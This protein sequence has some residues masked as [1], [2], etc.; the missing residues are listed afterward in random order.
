MKKKINEHYDLNGTPE[1]QIPLKKGQEHLA[2]SGGTVIYRFNNDT[3][4]L[5]LKGKDFEGT[6]ISFYLGTDNEVMKITKEGFFWKGKLVEN[7]K[8][9]YQKFKELLNKAN[10]SYRRISEFSWLTSRSIKVLC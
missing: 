7:D 5:T 9:I 3:S 1:Q 2:S 8:E 10:E 6:A 4:A